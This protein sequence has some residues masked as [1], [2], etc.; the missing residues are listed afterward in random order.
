MHET[1][2]EGP[3]A[4]Y[5]YCGCDVERLRP[6][7]LENK[8]WCS[9][10]LSFNDPYDCFPIVDTS[11]SGKEISAWAKKYIDKR[12]EG[13]AR[14]ERRRK[15]RAIAADIRKG[16]KL[17]PRA[18]S[19]G[20]DA[21]WRSMLDKMGVFSLSADPA[22]ILLWAHYGRSHSGV[23]LVFD[24]TR[25][26]FDRAL[27]VTYSDERPVFRSLA[28]DGRDAMIRCLL[29]K[30]GPWAYE[31]EWRY[32]IPGRTGWV[33]I[34]PQALTGVILGAS[35][36][37][38]DEVALRGLLDKREHPVTVERMW[39]KRDRFEMVVQAA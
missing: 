21:A 4:F 37:P 24:P 6:T 32:I 3:A 14:S 18:M 36:K 31:R 1:H 25:S 22:N 20:G 35:I 7:L 30:A 34:D 33:D 15:A 12:N 38:A 11:G 29:N 13:A 19:S 28:G 9:S 17:G 8:I 26:P 27:E 10:P 16:G 39:F 2:D 23:A 5:K